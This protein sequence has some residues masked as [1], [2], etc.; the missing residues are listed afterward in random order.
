[1][2]AEAFAPLDPETAQ[3]HMRVEDYAAVLA[4]LK[5]AFIH[6]DESK[7][8]LRAILLEQGCDPEMT[9]FDVPRLRTSTSDGYLTTGITLRFIRSRDTWYSAP[10]MQLNWWLPIF[11]RGRTMSWPF[12]PYSPRGI[13]NG[14]D[15]YNYY[16]WN[17]DSR[18]SRRR[19][20]AR[21]PGTAEASGAGRAGDPDSPVPPV[22][23]LMVFSGAQLR[24][25]VPN[26][27]GKTRISVDFRTVHHADVEAG[28]GAPNVDSACTGTTLRDYLR[29][30]DF[31]RL[32]TEIV[33]PYNEGV[34]PADL[35]YAIFRG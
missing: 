1:M 35:P 28:R 18:P 33:A 10:M 25:S 17:R 16:R 15:R 24:S 26:T 32:P 2:V 29:L 20:S 12:T 13:K 4:K 34:D 8:H 22:G 7:R 3:H 5:P 23:G 14:S 21:T 6:A 11:E 30:S 31:E 9:Y 19:R 27:S